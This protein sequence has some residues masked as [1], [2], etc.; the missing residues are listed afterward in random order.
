MNLELPSARAPK[1]TSQFLRIKC[2]RTRARSQT[3]KVSMGRL[4]IDLQTISLL[5]LARWAEEFSNRRS[6]RSSTVDAETITTGL[7]R[8]KTSGLL[9]AVEL[10]RGSF[11]SDD[12][13]IFVPPRLCTDLSLDMQQVDAFTILQRGSRRF[14]SFAMIFVSSP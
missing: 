6:N 5:V 4:E 9:R 10:L 12:E 14:L 8:S 7:R 2:H 11:E 1:G 13:I 3:A